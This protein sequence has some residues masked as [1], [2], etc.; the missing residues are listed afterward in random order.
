M[1]KVTVA[2]LQQ[3][4]PSKLKRNI[5][6]DLVNKINSIAGNEVE[7]D[8]FRENLLGYAHVLQEGKYKLEDYLNAVHY[9]SYR[10]LG[11]TMKDSYAKTFPHRYQRLVAR[12]T[13]ET[14]ISSFA[15]AYN[16]NK[17]VN[18]IMEQT[19]IPTH[20]L[21]ADVYQ[22]A[23]NTQATLM[24]TANS[25]KV[26]SDAAN[27]LLTHL[28]P[29]ETSKVEIDIKNSTHQSTIDEL[30]KE[31]QRL[32]AQQ[33]LSIQSGALNAKDVADS[34]II[35]GEYEHVGENR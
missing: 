25:E 32:A 6:D 17:L 22:E 2:Q 13:D 9:V 8:T 35:D 33:K 23:I 7:R 28:K 26:R 20:I 29:P 18:A 4:V 30:R 10:L 5:T 14:T 11:N 34:K 12:Q 21:N 19:L 16:K 31:T 24:R 1:S 27:S 3:V 15:S